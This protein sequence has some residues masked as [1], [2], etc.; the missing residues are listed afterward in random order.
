MKALDM[1]EGRG[2]NPYYAGNFDGESDELRDLRLT[3]V[4]ERDALKAT[5][6]HTIAECRDAYPV[7][8]VGSELE[9]LWGQAMGDPASVGA[10]VSACATSQ[11]KEI[12]ALKAENERLLA[13]NRDCIAHYE[14][15]RAELEHI[16]ANPVHQW[17]RPFSSDPSSYS[18]NDGRPDHTDG[19]GPYETRTLY[20]LGSKT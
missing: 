6:E 13:A 3:L 20:A 17:R 18:W 15:A 14:D 8:E 2:P 10:Y 4:A 11:K 16:K 12:D 7:P 19:G 1:A 9:G 5:F